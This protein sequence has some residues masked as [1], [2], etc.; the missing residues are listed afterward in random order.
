MLVTVPFPSSRE[1]VVLE[2]VLLSPFLGIPSRGSI[3]GGFCFDVPSLR[4]WSCL[5][6][7]AWGC[8]SA[9]SYGDAMRA[10]VFFHIKDVLARMFLEE[11]QSGM[12]L[13]M[14]YAG[15]VFDR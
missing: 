9:R 2:A 7:R 8:L 4:A 14:Q 5:F 13:K 15:R 3:K 11:T 12:G 6:L 10:H 1:P